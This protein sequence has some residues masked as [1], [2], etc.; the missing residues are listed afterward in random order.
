MAILVM[1]SQEGL[2]EMD[3]AAKAIDTSLRQG[4]VGVEKGIKD[5]LDS[6]NKGE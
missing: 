1:Y 6:I 5:S 2:D 4:I 3:A